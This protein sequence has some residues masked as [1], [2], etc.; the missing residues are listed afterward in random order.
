[1]AEGHS[2]DERA[3]DALER[4]LS[5]GSAGDPPPGIDAAATEAARRLLGGA[6][7][8]EPGPDFAEHLAARLAAQHPST[9]DRPPAEPPEDPPAGGGVPSW[10]L[11]G[12]GLLIG[13][14][15]L[16]LRGI[17]HPE[18]DPTA[19]PT[20][21]PAA[22]PTVPLVTQSVTPTGTPAGRPSAPATA[23]RSTMP[24]PHQFTTTPSSTPGATSV[25]AAPAREERAPEATDTARP[26]PTSTVTPA[27]TPTPT[28]EPTA[29]ATHSPTSVPEPTAT[30]TRTRHPDEPSPTPTKEPS[31]TPH[32][33]FTPTPDMEATERA[34]HQ[35][36]TAEARTPTST[37]D[38]AERHTPE[39]GAL[40][41][42]R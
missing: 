23:P 32:E 6:R 18:V 20:L 26:S 24:P 1:M 38:L 7:G 28:P 35:T 12:V 19:T 40:A 31:A 25:L 8:I 14:A 39:P 17:Q 33:E 30:P 5:S 16:A 9:T 2:F 34:I 15:L 42:R 22:S 10:A 37:D 11:A 27:S 36:R 4:W 21:Q 13:A 41:R 29:T 3:Y